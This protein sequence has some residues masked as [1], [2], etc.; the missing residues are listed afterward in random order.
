MQFIKEKQNRL[1][2]MLAA[3]F[4]TNTVVAEF[5]GVKI[6]SLEQTVGLSEMSFHFFGETIHGISLTCGVLLWP[7]VFIFT[8]IINEYFG[9]R[10]VRFLSIITAVM[11]AYTYVM[12]Q[13]A[14]GSEPASWWQASSQYGAAMNFNDA[15]H[16]VFSQGGNIIVG[17][18]IAFLLGQIIDVTVF[19]WVKKMTGERYIWLRSTGSTLVSQLIDSFIVLF[20][21]FYIAKLGTAQQWSINLVLA[22]CMVNY[23]Y[24]SAMAFL[25][26]PLIYL[27][28]WGIERYLGETLAK[29]LKDEA[30]GGA[31]Y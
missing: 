6:F 15:F 30:A 17:S 25:L 20:Y 16:A 23:I 8:D 9:T 12:L 29:R 5:M 24:K 19:H 21:A 26:T 4:V 2:I 18:L 31:A 22:V 14:M 1:F 3:F 27:L 7:F 13:L 11:V 10:G 28:H